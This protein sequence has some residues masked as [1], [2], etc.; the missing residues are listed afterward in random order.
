MKL[1]FFL[2]ILQLEEAATTWFNG[3]VA[4]ERITIKW[5]ADDSLDRIGDYIE[6]YRIILW[7]HAFNIFFGK[8][9]KYSRFLPFIGQEGMEH[10]M[11][12]CVYRY[13]YYS[14]L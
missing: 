3:T 8:K 5:D 11:L 2:N 14:L 9:S 1:I 4:S 7:D 12:R 6:R 10:V 13:F